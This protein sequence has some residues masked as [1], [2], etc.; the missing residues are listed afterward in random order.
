M[1][2]LHLLMS[3]LRM[4]PNSVKDDQ[5]LTEWGDTYNLKQMQERLWELLKEFLE[6]YVINFDSKE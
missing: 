5:I 1:I 4:V 3:F 6:P 2:E